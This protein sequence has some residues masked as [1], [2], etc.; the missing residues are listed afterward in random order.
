M[1]DI[2]KLQHDNKTIQSNLITKK[3]YFYHSFDNKF[4]SSELIKLLFLT[5][6]NVY[7]NKIMQ[8]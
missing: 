5:I 4:I 3:D 8:C 7:S 2:A 6:F 1:K